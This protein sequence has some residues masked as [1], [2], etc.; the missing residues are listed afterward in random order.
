V[1]R[2]RELVHDTD[3]HPTIRGAG[4]GVLFGLGAT[5]DLTI[6]RE[7]ESYLLGAPERVLQAGR[8]FDGVCRTARHVLVGRSRLLAAIHRV[9]AQL[10]WETFK[11]ILPDLRRAFTQFIPSELDAISSRVGEHLRLKASAEQGGA[12]SVGDEAERLVEQLAATDRRAATVL[13]RWLG[14]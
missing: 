7:L 2:L 13:V 3:G 4:F 14:G 8:F 10:D 9:L 1:R 12:E 6:A 5:R 11:R